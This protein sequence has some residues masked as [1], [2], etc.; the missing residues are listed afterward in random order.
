MVAYICLEACEEAALLNHAS[1]V[2]ILCAGAAPCAAF[3]PNTEALK[4]CV[5]LSHNIHRCT[6]PLRVIP[7][8]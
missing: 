5:V 2:S 3:A 8:T 7:S 4:E 6:R 1:A